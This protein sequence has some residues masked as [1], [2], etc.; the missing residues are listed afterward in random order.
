MVKKSV[1]DF[2]GFSITF[3]ITR[4]GFGLLALGVFAA[5][6]IAGQNSFRHSLITANYRAII[7]ASN[8]NVRNF[9]VNTS[10]DLS[11]TFKAE[12][13]VWPP[14]AQQTIP[15]LILAK[16]PADFTNMKDHRKRQDLFLSAL[17]PIVLIENRSIRE[18]RNLAKM[19]LEVEQPEHGS[20]MH[21]WLKNLAK[22][23]RVHGDLK[24]PEVIA[25]LL[26]RLDEIPP[27]LALAQSAIETG[28][29]TSRFA[30]E[31]NSLFGQWT[32]KRS[33]GLEPSNRAM[34][35]TH[36]VASFPSLRDSVRA[37]MRNL[38]VGHAYTEFRQERARL[39][40]EGN[41]LQAEGLAVYLHRY[42]QRGEHY[43]SDLQR[44]IKSRH[45]AFLANI[46][47]DPEEPKLF[48]ASLGTRY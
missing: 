2:S 11:Q 43:V 17:L 36:Y 27:A 1:K 32:F 6:L 40:A 48:M 15:P 8:L 29:G 18:Q 4:M 3:L 12:R 45:I 19:L 26:S 47:L 35:A 25:K 30:M 44:M 37:Y 5:V 46:N 16:L 31:G 10:Q 42:S 21:S 39:R 20:D 23:F 24:K 41:S 7:E 33:E 28:W 22:K 14:S 9:Q 38:N 34:D 13:Y